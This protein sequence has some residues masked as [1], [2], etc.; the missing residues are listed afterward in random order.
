M[1]SN[2]EPETPSTA[3]FAGQL[4]AETGQRQPADW[5]GMAEQ[6]G[7]SSGSWFVT[8]SQSIS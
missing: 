6:A 7:N 1:P 4:T 8:L 3:A 2:F 5:P